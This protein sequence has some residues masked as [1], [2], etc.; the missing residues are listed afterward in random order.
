MFGYHI[1]MLSNDYWLKPFK[2]EFGPYPLIKHVEKTSA[3]S[4]EKKMKNFI[5]FTCALPFHQFREM[6]PDIWSVAYQYIENVMV[7]VW[8]HSVKLWKIWNFG[9]HWGMVQLIQYDWWSTETLRNM[10]S[11]YLVPVVPA[12]CSINVNWVWVWVIIRNPR[13]TASFLDRFEI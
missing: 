11:Y 13:I 10:C 5:R 7:E 6:S 2:I 3:T 4:F 12:G 9:I 1:E 8:C